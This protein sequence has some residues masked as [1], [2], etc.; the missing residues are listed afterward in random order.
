MENLSFC[1]FPPVRPR[2][3]RRGSALF[4]DEQELQIWGEL[5]SIGKGRK[6]KE[7]NQKAFK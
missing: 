5:A 7:F 3:V 1:R 4:M 2:G 6:D